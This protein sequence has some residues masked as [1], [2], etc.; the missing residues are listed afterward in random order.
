[1]RTHNGVGK[2]LQVFP[3]LGAPWQRLVGTNLGPY[4]LCYLF[5]RRMDGVHIRYGRNED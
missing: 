3:D 5:D 1:M 2:Q 4:T